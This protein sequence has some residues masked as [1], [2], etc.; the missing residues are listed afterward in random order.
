MPLTYPWFLDDVFLSSIWTRWTGSWRRCFSS[1][2]ISAWDEDSSTWPKTRPWLMPSRDWVPIYVP[3]NRY[4]S[5]INLF[6][7][8][9]K[10]VTSTLDA[11]SSLLWWLCTAVGIY[12]ITYRTFYI[13]LLDEGDFHFQPMEHYCMHTLELH[14]RLQQTH[15]KI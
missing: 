14:I 12:S 15:R 13:L 3:L 10:P 6:S 2:L 4:V 5:S 1:S 11:C 7:I 9:R 8:S